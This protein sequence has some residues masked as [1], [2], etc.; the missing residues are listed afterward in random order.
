MARPL[1]IQFPGAIYHLTTRGVDRQPIFR[2][3]DDRLA[4]LRLLDRVSSLFHNLT[5][6][7]TSPES[8]RR[9]VVFPAPFG[10]ASA[11][12][13]RRSTLNETPSKS[14]SPESSL[15]RFE[16]MRTATG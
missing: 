5:S 11:S 13:S 8:A 14:G 1:R 16:A 15:R 2:D 4:F 12:R 10:P 9:S 7:E 6:S 3:R